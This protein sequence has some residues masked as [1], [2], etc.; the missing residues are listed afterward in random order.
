[1]AKKIVF[2][3]VAI[4]FATYQYAIGKKLE[5]KGVG[6]SYVTYSKEAANFLKKRECD[7]SYIPDVVKNY[8]IKD[9]TE[10]VL[11][12]I[13]EKYGV[14][15]DL[16]LFGD[17]D[18]SFMRREKAFKS[19]IKNFMFWEDYLKNKKVDAI[20]GSTERFVGMIPYAVAKKHNTK[21]IIWTRAVIPNHFV[22]T[23]DQMGHW[24]VLD[25][26][27]E[28]NK[29]RKLT[30]EEKE[31]A[32]EI[33]NHI[34]EKKKSLYLVVGTPVVTPKEILFFLKRLYLN[35]FVEKFRNP[36]ARVMGIALEKAKKAIRKYFVKP[37]Y[38]KPDYNE[39][40]FFHPLHVE[41]DAQI[42]VRAPQYFNQVALISY[43][44]KCLPVGYKLYIEEHPNNRGGTPIKILKKFKEIPNVKL[45]HPS[46]HG[47]DV[48]RHASGITTI[49][50]TIGWESLLYKKPV[51]NFGPCF[52]EVSGLTYSLRDL[53]KLPETIKKALEK[54]DFDEEKLLRFVNAVL[55]SVYP[56]NLNFYYQFA[57]KAMTDENISLIA[58]GISKELT[59]S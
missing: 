20:I 15:A 6:I 5:E 54:K 12:K 10:N 18:H 14:N 48:I 28:R 33:I 24:S 52:Y 29:N 47:H 19:M 40:Y 7:V 34:I 50:N 11:R 59:K 51:I 37:L 32:K 56:G 4:H 9:S 43:I 42:L 58:K 16:I 22:L 38:S 41:N 49:N 21:Y 26:Y 36:Y 57:K 53:T 2:I 31:K 55:K 46:T 35:I 13:E 39:K 27:W 3:N 45:L 17:Y 1:M 30:L 23:E 44:A 25:K 8:K